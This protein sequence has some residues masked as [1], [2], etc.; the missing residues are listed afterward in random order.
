MTALISAELLRLRTIRSPRYVALG[1]LAFVA[2][3]A[4]MPLLDPG[5]VPADSSQ[6]GESMRSLAL[7]GVII[8]A[9]FGAAN[10]GTEFKRGA[11]ALTYLAHPRRGRVTAA[12]ALT[13]AG[14]SFAFATVA[15]GVVVAAGLAVAADQD[16]DAGLTVTAGARIVFGAVFGAGFGG[17][18][19]GAAGFLLGTVTRNPTVASGAVVGW[20]IGESLLAV[21]G[22]GSYL[23]F[24]LVGSLMGKPGGAPL[25]AA[26]LLLPAY[27]A[28]F[29]LFVRAWAL[30]RDVT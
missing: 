6:L 12:R 10:A 25:A 20:N 19:I 21:A 23:P 14:L 9:T 26:L 22:I 4:L 27:L 13:Y 11:T 18:V 16:I 30:P 8:G 3:L 5:A 17:A 1:I 2:V 28:A 7:V 15:A 29:A 24:G